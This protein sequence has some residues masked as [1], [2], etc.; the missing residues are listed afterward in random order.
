MPVGGLPPDPDVEAILDRFNDLLRDQ[1]DHPD[2]IS[3][4]RMSGA[5][6]QLVHRRDRARGLR[7]GS[8]EQRTSPGRWLVATPS[9]SILP[10]V[11]S[12]NWS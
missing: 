5:H 4:A 9:T 6:A 11:R 12:V 10:A 8:S 2:D 7:E 1:A 3:E